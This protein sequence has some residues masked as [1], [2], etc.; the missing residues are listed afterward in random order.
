[1]VGG[2]GIFVELAPA[3]SAFA[4]RA[5]YDGPEGFT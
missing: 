3:R 1:M 2:P 4:G 5:R